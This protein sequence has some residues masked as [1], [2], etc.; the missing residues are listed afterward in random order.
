MKREGMVLNHPVFIARNLEHIGAYSSS[1]LNDVRCIEGNEETEPPSIVCLEVFPVKEVI[2][3]DDSLA[4]SHHFVW[5]TEPLNDLRKTRLAVL[6]EVHILDR[7]GFVEGYSFPHDRTPETSG[8]QH[9]AEHC[10]Q[11]CPQSWRH[12][13]VVEIQWLIERPELELEWRSSL[14]C[15][16]V[17]HDAGAVE[18]D[19]HVVA[20]DVGPRE[21]QHIS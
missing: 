17:L 18:N 6:D 19:E 14:S 15:H 11:T 21:E 20:L 8:K 10:Y 1:L 4:R 2:P 16:D 12:H 13:A 9:K 5:R 3:S 7:K